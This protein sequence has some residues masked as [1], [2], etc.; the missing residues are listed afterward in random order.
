MSNE[1]SIK[2]NI[3]SEYDEQSKDFEKQ[4]QHDMEKAIK[5]VCLKHAVDSYMITVDQ[6]L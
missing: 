1:I 2:V 6:I 5:A 4:M 3:D